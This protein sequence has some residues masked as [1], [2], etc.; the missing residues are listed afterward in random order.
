MGNVIHYE[1]HV[2]A[3]IQPGTFDALAADFTQELRRSF[4]TY[5]TS[6]LPEATFRAFYYSNLSVEAYTRGDLDAAERLA[7]EALV[8]DPKSPVAW[9]ILGVVRA[10][11]GD[12][13]GAEAAYRKAM[14]LDPKD[15]S[16]VG[17]MEVLMTS[18]GRPEEAARY[19][20]LGERTR[21]ADPYF[22]AFLAEEALD[23]GHLFEATDQVRAALKILPK[24]PA[25]FLIL[26]RV[27]L[28]TG[29][30]EGAV[31]EVEKAREL[32]E[33]GQRARYDSKIAAIMEL[34]PAL[35]N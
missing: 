25:F 5:I 27:K 8:I 4:G 16:P 26:A 29:D 18:A 17:N 31:K 22:H 33:P 7:Q 24:E 23:D 2:V 19:R 30:G 28:A 10:G 9:N 12:V 13:A 20:Q 11:Q 14:A 32:S 15:G 21:K 3:A 35:Q 6:V 1:R 34:R